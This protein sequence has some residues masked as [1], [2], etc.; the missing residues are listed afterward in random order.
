MVKHY[1]I[2]IFLVVLMI[3]GCFP[4]IYAISMDQDDKVMGINNVSVDGS[5]TIYVAKNGTDRNEGLTPEKPKRNLKNA[6]NDANPGDT[7]KVAQGTYPQNLVLSKNITLIGEDQ[8][9]TI[10]AAQPTTRIDWNTT[11][12]C[13]IVT[14]ATVTITGFTIKNGNATN[15]YRGYLGGGIKNEGTLIIKN[16]TIT[17]NLAEMGSGIDNMGIMNMSGVTIIDNT[18]TAWGGGIDNSLGTM[19][20]EDSTITN[21]HVVSNYGGGGIINCDKM[22]I[23]RVNVTNNTC[24]GYSG[25]IENRGLLT[26]EDSIIA[27]NTAEAGGGISNGGSIYIYGSIITHNKAKKGGGFFNGVD[28]SV[29]AYIDDLTVIKDNIVNDFGGK[30]FMPA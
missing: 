15:G 16:S 4:V 28:K 6:I 8:S 9:N 14:G 21:N 18:A 1:K 7:I 2:K 12:S 22:I 26:I 17:N 25:G 5:K 29:E 11:T 20:I 10:I 13:I 24:N 27:N 30:P 23:R 19:L 3:M